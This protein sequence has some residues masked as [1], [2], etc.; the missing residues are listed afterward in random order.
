MAKQKRKGPHGGSGPSGS[1][2]AKT[3]EEEDQKQQEAEEAEI[4]ENL[5]EAHLASKYE[6]AGDEGVAAK[7]EATAEG[8]EEKAAKADPYLL[9]DAAYIQKDTRW[10]N[11][12]RTLIFCSRGVTSLFRHLMEDFKKL[13]P[14]H[15]SEPKF[16]KKLKTAEINEIAELKNCNNVIFFEARRKKDLYLW[17]ARVPLGPCMKFQVLNIHTTQEV[18]L[19]GNCLLGSRPIIYFDKHFSEL[20]HLKVMKELMLQ[21]MGTPRNHPKSK[22][23]HDHVISFYWLDHKIWFRHYQVVPEVP[24]AMNEPERQQLVE[25]G[26]RFVLDPIRIFSGSF[27]GPTIFDNAFYMSPQALKK[28]MLEVSREKTKYVRK[29]KKLAAREKKIE[30]TELPPDPLDEAFI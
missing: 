9:A 29:K 30:A 25:I 20:P 23:F 22:P 12:Q 2:R 18:R 21:A 5:D 4:K 6:S 14:H 3:A 7:P 24:E 16:E 15:K 1:K 26:P 10:R 8:E 28:H 27:G 11:K 19:A 13:V 17:L